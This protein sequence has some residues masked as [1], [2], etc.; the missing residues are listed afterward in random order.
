[1]IVTL[2]YSVQFENRGRAFTEKVIC[3]I[4]CRSPRNPM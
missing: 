1:M 2:F 4:C 3:Y